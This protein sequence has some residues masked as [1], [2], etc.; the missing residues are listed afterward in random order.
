LGDFMKNSGKNTDMLFRDMLV[1][2]TKI[3]LTFFVEPTIKL[4][5]EKLAVHQKIGVS[6]LI[7]LVMHDFLKARKTAD[8][9]RKIEGRT[10][11]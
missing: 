3:P 1:E 11:K 7:R 4:K 5:L 9:L 10:R 8:I 6:S 2:E